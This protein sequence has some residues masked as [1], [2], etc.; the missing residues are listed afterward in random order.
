MFFGFFFNF[1]FIK[2]PIVLYENI[3]EDLKN[4]SLKL[5][6]LV[7]KSPWSGISNCIKQARLT[8]LFLN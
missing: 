2:K 3:S 8:V 4:E 7:G 1:K 6:V 5:S